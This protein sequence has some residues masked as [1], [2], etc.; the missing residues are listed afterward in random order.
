MPDLAIRLVIVAVIAGAAVLVAWISRHRAAPGHPHVELLDSGI[1]GDVVIFTSTACPDCRQAIES[2]KRTG[3]A[4]REVTW[5]IEP[6]AVAR[7]G[8]VGVPLI[9]ARG[10]G[11]ETV[12]QVAGVPRRRDLDALIAKAGK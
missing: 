10:S 5:E 2:L 4:Y 3:V 12:G 11:G 6:D 7:L 9:V 8:V 1:S